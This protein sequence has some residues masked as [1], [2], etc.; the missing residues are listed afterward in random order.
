MRGR[1]TC[2]CAQIGCGQAACEPS[3]SLPASVGWGSRL[4]NMR[5]PLSLAEVD[6]SLLTLALRLR[7]V[8][9]LDA[10]VKESKRTS[11]TGGRTSGRRFCI[12]VCSS[13][14]CPSLPKPCPLFRRASW[15]STILLRLPVCDAPT[16]CPTP[17]QAFS[18]P[19]SPPWPSR[20]PS[21]LRSSRRSLS[22]AAILWSPSYD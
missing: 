7:N 2:G 4:A 11:A 17:S 14:L 1:M 10:A 20:Q 15:R 19:R 16:L 22:P 9:R 18:Q 6:S 21:S 8:P 13:P 5:R 12:K 3:A